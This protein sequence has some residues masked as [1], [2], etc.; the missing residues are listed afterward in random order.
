VNLSNFIVNL[1]YA[2]IIFLL[3]TL[4]VANNIPEEAKNV[5]ALWISCY[6]VS[7]FQEVCQIGSSYARTLSGQSFQDASGRSGLSS[8]GDIT[9]HVFGC[10]DHPRRQHLGLAAARGNSI[11]TRAGNDNPPV[12]ARLGDDGKMRKELSAAYPARLHIIYE[13]TSQ[14][15]GDV[16]AGTVIE[17]DGKDRFDFIAYLDLYGSRLG[18]AVTQIR[19]VFNDLLVRKARTSHDPNDVIG[20]QFKYAPTA[21]GDDLNS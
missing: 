20:V 1:I 10:A 18:Q 8:L 14:P 9:I 5:I 12:K 2:Q 13:T 7:E 15:G 3:Y 6:E 17:I 21:Q 11:E 19:S 4:Y 16:H